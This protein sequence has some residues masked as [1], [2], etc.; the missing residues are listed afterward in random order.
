[1]NELRCPPYRTARELKQS[2][3]EKI[4]INKLLADA[5]RASAKNIEKQ[6]QI[7]DRFIKLLE[8]RGIGNEE[9]GN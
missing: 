8:E 7:L 5:Y 1:M 4:V 2:M 3:N 9:S 6:I